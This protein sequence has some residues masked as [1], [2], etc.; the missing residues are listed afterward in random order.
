MKI[1]EGKY[2]V[3]DRIF[4]YYMLFFSLLAIVEI[5]SNIFY[6]LKFFYNYKWIMTFISSSLLMCLSLKS[7]NTKLLKRIGIYFGAFAIIPMAWIDSPG[8]QSSSILYSFLILIMIN[9]LLVGIERIILT[10]LYTGENLSIIFLYLKHPD[11]FKPLTIKQQNLDWMISIPTIFFFTSILLI[12]FERAYERER[13]K[14]ESTSIILKKKSQT[15]YLTGLFNREHLSENWPRLLNL[16]R[17]RNDSISLI[18]FDIDF[19]K[20]YNDHYGHPMGDKCLV[21]FA[22]ILESNTEREFDFAYR[23]GG[24]EFLIILGQTNKRGAVNVA[25]K[26][27]KALENTAIPHEYSSVDKIVTATA[28]ITTFVVGENEKSCEVLINEADQALYNGKNNGRNRI[29]CYSEEA[30]INSL[31]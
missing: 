10:F 2:S 13:R 4:I 31:K 26:I 9:Y 25:K 24:E 14:N 17:R 3:K 1:K 7:K 22:H 29:V 19:F 12:T 27:M 11:F 28:G 21:S 5:V 16:H 30:Y 15:D 6:G 8:I 23:L 20:N 18:M